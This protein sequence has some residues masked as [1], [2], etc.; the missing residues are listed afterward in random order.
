MKKYY[1]IYIFL[2]L[3][4]SFAIGATV[5]AARFELSPSTGTYMAGCDSSIAIMMS[6]EGAESDAANILVHYN[7]A[8]IE[9]IDNNGTVPGVQ[10]APGSTYDIYADNTVDTTAGIIRLTGFSIGHAYNSGSGF[11][12][13]GSIPFRSRPGVLS[14]AVTIEYVPG[15]TTDSNI[16]EYITS[17]DLLTGVTNGSYTFVVGPCV[18]DTTPPYVTNPDPAPGAEGVPLDSNVAFNIRDNR[19]GVDINSVR[20]NIQGIDYT[21]DG[22]NRFSYTGDPLNYRIVVD[23]IENFLEGVIVRVEIRAQDLALNVMSPYRYYFNRPPEPPP[24]PPTCEELGCP[25]AEECPIPEPIPECIEPE[26][27]D[28][29]D[30]TVSPDEALSSVDIQFWA[31][32]RTVRL[33]PDGQ[34]TVKVLFGTSYSVVIPQDVFPKEADSIWWYVGQSTYQMAID[35]NQGVYWGDFGALGSVTAVPAHLIVNYYDGTTD[36]VDFTV[37]TVAFGSVYEVIGQERAALENAQVTVWQVQSPGVVW[38]A[39]AYN[40]K[41][42]I[43]TPANGQFGFYVPQ[44]YYY[45]E[46]EKPGFVTVQTPTHYARTSI[47]NNVVSLEQKEVEVTIIESITQSLV[48]TG[49]KAN[50]TLNKFRDAVL[51]LLPGTPEQLKN[52]S[53]FAA[54]IAAAIAL[55]NL[56]TAISLANLLPFLWGLFTQPMLLFGRRKRKKWGVVYNSISKMPIDLAVVRLIDN[57]TGGILR[58]RITDKEG[59][60]FFMAK[61]GLYKLS[62]A[63]PGFIFPTVLLRQVKEDFQYIDVYHGELIE[64]KKDSRQITANI[65]I[66]PVVPTEKP[67]KLVFR[68]YLRKIQLAIASISIFLALGLLLVNPSWLMLGY[69]ALQVLIFALFWRLAR[70]RKPRGWG[71]VYDRKSNE[72]LTSAIVRIF[73]RQFSRLLETQITDNQGRYSFLVGNNQYFTTYEKPGYIPKKLS[74]IDFRGREEGTLVNYDVGLDPETGAKSEG[75]RLESQYKAQIKVGPSAPPTPGTWQPEEPEPEQK[76]Q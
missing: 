32:S 48:E 26:V 23:P 57:K 5:N 21:Y 36:V 53:D 47:I 45:L 29:P 17:D 13:F 70:P 43:W 51:D 54:P 76:Q 1:P 31:A 39:G 14:T 74:P 72:P 69:F 59:R 10:I 4:A 19:S 34:N 71:I 3:L 42:P 38:N 22:V 8:D 30:T 65:P 52:L 68:F 9:I 7:P 2:T 62:V 64:V 28:I 55:L 11:G 15:S 6:T 75:G 44:G 50:S 61:P 12:A 24:I 66:D 46:I 35:A 63:K 18:A 37:Q 20:V 56:G 58:T 16:A 41:N 33:I 40:Q 49:D 73:D 60:Y 67:K 25:E 27:I